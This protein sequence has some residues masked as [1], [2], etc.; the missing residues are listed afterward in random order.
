METYYQT[1]TIKVKIKCPDIVKEKISDPETV[2]K[3]IQGIYADL[4][5]D[6]EHFTILAMNKANQINGFK[7]VHS[8]GIDESL[9]NIPTVF[10][11][12]LLFGATAIIAVHN[13]PS[14]RI[15]PSQEDITLTRKLVEAGKVIGVKV[16]DHIIIASGGY[17]SFQEH[18][19]I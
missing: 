8:G 18:R 14:G 19:L 7:V 6:Q 3:V 10:R 1:K 12:A 15:E 4:D 13:H 16:M 9:V 17:Y 2:V 11:F 5:A